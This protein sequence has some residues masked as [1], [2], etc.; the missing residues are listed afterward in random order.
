MAEVGM[1]LLVHG[2]VTDASVDLFDRE[3]VFIETVLKPV[4]S[5][6]PTLK[7]VMEHITTEGNFYCNST[8]LC[9]PITTLT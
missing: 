9:Q 2:E 8:D 5:R 6:H 1:L 7:I 4:I 3:K